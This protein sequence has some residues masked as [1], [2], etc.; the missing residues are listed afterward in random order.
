MGESNGKCYLVM[1]YIEGK[2]IGALITAEGP[3]P[4]ADRRAACAAGRAG[5]GACAT[6]KG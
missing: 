3:M 4:A 2:N 5:A 1:E 6:A